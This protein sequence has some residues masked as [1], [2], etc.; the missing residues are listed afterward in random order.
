ML[1]IA[2]IWQFL[3]FFMYYLVNSHSVTNAACNADG[4]YSNALNKSKI[5]KKMKNSSG[6]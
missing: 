4:F 6:K 1:P 3:Y 5:S 2:Y